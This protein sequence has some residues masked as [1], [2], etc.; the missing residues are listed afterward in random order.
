M[1]FSLY[2][3]CR[4]AILSVTTKSAT[5]DI[6]RTGTSITT[7][8]VSYG[9]TLQATH[10]HVKLCRVPLQNVTQSPN[11]FTEEGIDWLE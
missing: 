10:F 8:I 3:V 1:P 9:L 5:E 11:L 6:C 4:R 7:V 2:G